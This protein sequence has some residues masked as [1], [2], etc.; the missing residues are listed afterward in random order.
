LTKNDY[1][2]LAGGGCKSLSDLNGTH[3]HSFITD[4]TNR[5]FYDS[6]YSAG[7]YTW[8]YNPLGLTG[9]ANIHGW[10]FKDTNLGTDIGVI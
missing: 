3:K 1:I 5:P 6:E 2:L 8:S 10:S 4:I 9:I 7:E